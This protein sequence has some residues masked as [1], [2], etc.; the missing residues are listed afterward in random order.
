[1]S[2]RWCGAEVWRTGCRFRYRPRHLTTVQSYE[3]SSK[4]SFRNLPPPSRYHS[5]R[6]GAKTVP[7]S[8]VGFTVVAI[9]AGFGGEVEGVVGSSIMDDHSRDNLEDGEGWTV[10]VCRYQGMGD[11][12]CEHKCVIEGDG[13]LDW[14]ALASDCVAVSVNGV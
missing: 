12:R 6:F 14:E 3:V 4:N 5:N 13:S 7:T 8:G 11:V 10:I 1:M 9:F 2:S